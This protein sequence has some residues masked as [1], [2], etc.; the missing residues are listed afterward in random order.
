M[1]HAGLL[2]NIGDELQTIHAFWHLFCAARQCG[3]KR[4]RRGS[5][6]PK[7]RTAAWTFNNGML[8]RCGATR[9]RQEK[10][11]KPGRGRRSALI[12][13]PQGGL[14]CTILARYSA[15]HHRPLEPATDTWKLPIV[16][17]VKSHCL[18][19]DATSR[20]LRRAK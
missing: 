11:G 12:Y 13:N 15:S 14:S 17:Y 8:T 19:A 7:R 20:N 4:Q 16:V 10:K 9:I 5:S 6:P 3:I 1:V 2:R 18:K